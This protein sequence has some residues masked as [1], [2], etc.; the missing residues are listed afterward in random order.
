MARRNDLYVVSERRIQ[1]L[2]RRDHGLSPIVEPQSSPV[3]T[4]AGLP[5]PG[6][7]FISYRRQDNVAAYVAASLY[8]RLTR[9]FGDDMVF[10][11]IDSIEP[12]DDFVEKI[13][14]AVESCA[15]LLALIGDGWVEMTNEAGQR[16]L[17]DPEDFVR[18]EI[19]AALARNVRVIPVL[20]GEAKP[21]IGA[22]LRHGDPSGSRPS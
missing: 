13:N 9:E 4:A 19:E 10:Q 12:G 7:I 17:D 22:L 16:R 1:E 11:D 2:M 8:E 18:L 21:G 6:P 20:V 3:A 14:N 15:V 5:V